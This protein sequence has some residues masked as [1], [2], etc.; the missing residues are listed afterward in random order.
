MI[1]R[2]TMTDG[3]HVLEQLKQRQVR[4][5]KWDAWNLVE[6]RV[7]RP[8]DRLSERMARLNQLKEQTTPPVSPSAPS[9]ERMAMIKGVKQVSHY[10]LNEG[11]C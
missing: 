8:T 2:Q 1:S 7:Y 4:G 10:R 5:P 9:V 6:S 3:R 11:K